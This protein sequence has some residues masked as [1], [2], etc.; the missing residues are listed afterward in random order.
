MQ[1]L[2]K[3]TTSRTLKDT[4]KLEISVLNLL[5]RSDKAV[6]FLVEA[7]ITKVTKFTCKRFQ[8][9]PHPCENDS[10]EFTVHQPDSQSTVNILFLK[11]GSPHS[12]YRSVDGTSL[13]CIYI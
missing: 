7:W 10:Y 5:L 4:A 2:N 3:S 8:Q 1:K 6:Q 13:K 11:D 9:D 12:V